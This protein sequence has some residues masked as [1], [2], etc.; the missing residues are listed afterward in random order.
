MTASVS[1][2]RSP[3]QVTS[4]RE[5]GHAEDSGPLRIRAAWSP[6]LH[7]FDF[8]LISSGS[9]SLELP[10]LP[11]TFL[12]Q[13]GIRFLRYKT[14]KS[15]CVDP[16]P[17]FSSQITAW[18]ISSIQACMSFV[19]ESCQLCLQN[20]HPLPTSHSL[21]LTWS[22]SCQDCGRHLPASFPALTPAP[23]RLL[24]L[25]ARHSPAYNIP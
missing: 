21:P 6:L 2:Y 10:H 11:V 20:T 16:P 23:H 24:A 25:L 18:I 3:R 17:R 7:C 8:C 1:A 15:F 19:R 4:M 14:H 13:L 12:E 22:Q 5:A 9:V